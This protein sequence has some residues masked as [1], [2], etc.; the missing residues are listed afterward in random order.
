MGDFAKLGRVLTLRD[1]SAKVEQVSRLNAGIM[2]Y[3][4]LRSAGHK[5]AQS[6]AM[7]RYLADQYMVEYNH[8]ERPLIYG[9]KGLGTLG[10]PFGLFKTFQHNYLAQLV[11]YVNVYKHTGQSAPMV[12][13]FAQMIFS[14]G[15][16]GVIGIETADALLEKL[17]P[18]LEKFTNKP[19]PTIKEAIATSE[20]PDVIKHGIPSGMSGIDFTTTLA[21]PGTDVTDLVSVPTLDMWGL[22]PLRF[23]NERGILPSGVNLISV[24]VGSRSDLERKQAVVQFLKTTAPTSLHFAIEQYYNGLPVGYDFINTDMLSFIDPNY[25]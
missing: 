9:D 10:K 1:V 11:E 14:A 20:Y 15:L 8:L 3:N 24:I 16:F 6:K 12:A 25:A 7:A 18:T 5:P 19:I 23:W 22:N 4:F 17:S 13:F 2:F 21:A